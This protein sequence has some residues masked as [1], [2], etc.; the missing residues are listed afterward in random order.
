M[1]DAHDAESNDDPL[2]DAR[3]VADIAKDA[4]LDCCDD[5][6]PTVAAFLRRVRRSNISRPASCKNDADSMQTCSKR[7]RW[8]VS[9]SP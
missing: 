1:L 5:I 3:D 4:A 2:N 9:W 7:T 6:P 8:R